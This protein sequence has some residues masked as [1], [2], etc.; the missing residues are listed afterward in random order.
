MAK[1]MEF[2]GLKKVEKP[3]KY[4]QFVWNLSGKCQKKDLLNGTQFH[5][6]FLMEL[7]VC[8]RLAS[9]SYHNIMYFGR[10]WSTELVRGYRVGMGQQLGATAKQFIEQN[11]YVAPFNR[12]RR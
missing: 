11:I 3:K 12:P 2:Q 8:Y 5:V 7:C 1:K 10:T 6:H 9:I 4:E